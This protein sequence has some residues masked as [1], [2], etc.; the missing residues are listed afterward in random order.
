[1]WKEEMWK[2]RGRKRGRNEEMKKKE[3]KKN[4]RAC[5]PQTLFYLS[6]CLFLHLFLIAFNAFFL[7]LLACLFV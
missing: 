5:T 3:R 1:M 4:V 7:F 6:V 2:D